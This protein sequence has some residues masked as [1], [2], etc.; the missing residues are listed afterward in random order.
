MIDKAQ[1]V[2]AL[3]FCS[4]LMVK[5]MRSISILLKMAIVIED[6]PSSH[7]AILMMNLRKQG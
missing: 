7:T 6:D 3:L 5:R 2:A 1:R 4:Q